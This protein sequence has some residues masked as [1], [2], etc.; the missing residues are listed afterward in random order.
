MPIVL[1]SPQMVSLKKKSIV[2]QPRLSQCKLM[3]KKSFWAL[4]EV[5]I[6]RFGHC[7]KL[8][9]KSSALPGGLVKLHKH[10]VQYFPRCNQWKLFIK[11]SPLINSH[12]SISKPRL[13]NVKGRSAPLSI[14]HVKNVHLNSS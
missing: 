7:V 11:S 9:S 2:L 5:V 14:N 3:G 12:I 10:R 1:H 4:R 13:C 8:A 6:T